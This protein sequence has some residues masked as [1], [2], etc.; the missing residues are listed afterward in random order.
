[1]AV[2]LVVVRPAGP[3]TTGGTAV[4]AFL[5]WA[6]GCCCG[7]WAP[8]D[9]HKYARNMLSCNFNISVFHIVVLFNLSKEMVDIPSNTTKQ[10]ILVFTLATCFG[11]FL[12]HHQASAYNYRSVHMY[13]CIVISRCLMMAK[14]Y[15]ETCSISEN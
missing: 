4:A 6:G 15:A 7:W 12:G 9:G 2:L 3:T 1:V 14:K 8:D 10:C 11:L 5:R 13:S